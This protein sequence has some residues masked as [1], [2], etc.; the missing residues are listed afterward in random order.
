MSRGLVTRVRW[1]ALTR[2][3]AFPLHF[4]LERASKS[5]KGTEEETLKVQAED[6][7]DQEICPSD[8]VEPAWGQL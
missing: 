7:E 8:R 3:L 6:Q 4:L 2:Y 5:L 1:Y